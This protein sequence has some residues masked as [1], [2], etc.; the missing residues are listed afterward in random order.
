M[1]HG[2]KN[3]NLK[4]KKLARSTKAKWDTHPQV[5][6]ASLKCDRGDQNV[7][8]VPVKGVG[9]LTFGGGRMGVSWEITIDSDH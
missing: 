3:L 2:K 9:E 5:S 8:N 4:K 6:A 1:I 7:L